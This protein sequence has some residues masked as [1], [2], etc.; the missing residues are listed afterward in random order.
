MNI[1]WLDYISPVQ[2]E[3]TVAMD[4]SETYK[5]THKRTHYKTSLRHTTKILLLAKC[6]T[7]SWQTTG[8]FLISREFTQWYTVTFQAAKKCQ[9]PEQTWHIHTCTYIHTHEQTN[10]HTDHNMIAVNLLES[11]HF[12]S[13]TVL[14]GLGLDLA[15]TG[16][17]CKLDSLSFGHTICEFECFN[18]SNMLW[19]L[20]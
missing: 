13:L 19:L 20:R 9:A 18:S 16:L 11:V 12:V 3:H 4:W 2:C 15:L 8:F 10:I 7:W 14:P 17:F 6:C 5:W 1:K